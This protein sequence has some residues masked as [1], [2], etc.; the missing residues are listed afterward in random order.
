MDPLVSTKKKY[1]IIYFNMGG[2][3]N[4]DEVRPFLYNLFSDSEIINLPWF[5]KPFQ[6]RLAWLVAKF[7]SK[8]TKKMYGL[9]GGRSITNEITLK[10]ANGVTVELQNKGI[11]TTS[12]LAMRYAAPRVY[13]AIELLEKEDITTLVLFT[14]YPHYAKSTTGSSYN[15]F[16]NHLNGSHL[17]DL[18]TIVIED[19][20]NEVEYIN[21]WVNGI[22][23]KVTNLKIPIDENLHIVFTSHGLPMKYI[24][25]GETYPE[26]IESAKTEIVN[27]LGEIGTNSSIH[28][29]YQSKAGP[30]PWLQPYTHNKLEE[31][32]KLSPSA[33]IMVPLGFVSNNV[34]TLYEIDILYADLAESL[35]ITNYIRVEVPDHNPLYTKEI[36]NMLYRYIEESN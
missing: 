16:Y 36:A 11:E 10:L 21:W 5:L 31:I 8:A 32:S 22:T 28:L 23:D 27:K 30:L 7:R 26:K 34:E 35:G 2:P 6:K 19:W 9:I 33:V 25:A 18:E 12:V 1:G 3:D 20:G 4:L 29:A 13:E 24:K 14:Q 17:K 15:D